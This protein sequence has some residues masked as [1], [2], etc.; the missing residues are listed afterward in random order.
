MSLTPIILFTLC[1]N[2]GCPAPWVLETSTWTNTNSA[3]EALKRIIV[4]AKD[5]WNSP[6]RVVEGTLL[7]DGKTR[8]KYPING[9]R[10]L[11]TTILLH[12][13]NT[14]DRL[15]DFFI[16]RELNPRVLF[17]IDLK[18]LCELRPGL[19]GWALSQLLPRR[20]SGQPILFDDLSNVTNSMWLVVVFQAFYVIDALWN[21]HAILTTM[22]ITTDG[23]G[24]MLN[25]GILCGCRSLIPFKRGTWHLGRVRMGE[26]NAFRT[27]PDSPSVKY[28][29]YMETESGSKLLISG[30]WGLARHINYTDWDRYCAIVPYR[31]I[32]Y[33]Y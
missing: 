32:P 13:G 31:F 19:I 16:G 25:F 3:T 33:V 10:A 20:K 9:F 4:P 11:L 15:Y 30:W 22:D 1:N 17:G 12:L 6:G 7:R 24:F 21:E 14:G 29:K 5:A 2:D 18:Y 23:F 8:L 28:L 26:K 27:N